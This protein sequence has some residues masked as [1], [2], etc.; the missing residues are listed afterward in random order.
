MSPDCTCGHPQSKHKLGKNGCRG[1]DIGCARFVPETPAELAVEP[2]LAEELAAVAEEAD[3]APECSC[4]MS[5]SSMVSCAVHGYDAPDPDRPMVER[6]EPQSAEDSRSTSARLREVERELAA[7]D[8]AAGRDIAKPDEPLVERVADLLRGRTE[9]TERALEL[10]AELRGARDEVDTLTVQLEHAEQYARDLQDNGDVPTTT[11]HLLAQADATKVPAIVRTGDSIRDLIGQLREQ[12]AEH[13]RVDGLRTELAQIEER[14]EQLRAEIAK[15]EADEPAKPQ[16][17]D[18]EV[19]E[20]ARAMRI[21]VDPRGRV[22]MALRNRYLEA[23]S[24]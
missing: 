13:D 19:R 3:E 2:V 14:A 22:S 11:D 15:A 9:A 6:V 1:C 18:R 23:T 24:A 7:V 12:L 20:W 16:P 8:A 17:T 4:A 21:D 10:A 5:E